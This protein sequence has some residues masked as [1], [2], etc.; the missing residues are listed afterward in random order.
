M[1]EL[2]DSGKI[3][4]DQIPA[5]RPFEV[6]TVANQTERLAIEGALAG[7]IAIQQDTSTSFILNNDLDSQFLAFD[8]DPTVQ[9]TLGDIFTGSTSGGRIQATEYRTGVVH[10]INITD[11]GS[12]YTSP[13]AVTFAGGNPGLG[14]ISCAATTTIANGEVV[15][16]TIVEFNG[17]KGG[18]GYTSAPTVNIA[19]PSGAGTGATATAFIESR[20]YGDVVNRILIADTDTFDSSDIPPVTIDITRVVNTSSNNNNNW[21]SLSSNQIAATDITSGVIETDRLASGGAA[22]SFTF[23]RGDQNFA[24]AVQSIKGSETRYFA[25]LLSQANSGSSQLEF[26]TNSDV[27]VGH[28]VKNTVVGIQA[29]TNITGVITDAQLGGTTISLN[30]PITQNIAAGTIIEFERGGSP[31]VFESSYTKVILLIALLSYL[32]VMDLP[33]VNTSMLISILLQV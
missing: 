13:P 30:N 12:G 4:I 26:A 15:T 10:R 1:V 16:I 22:N 5:L 8:V 14:A 29:N 20:L 23:L 24:L 21:V 18:K 3:S 17:L 31:M 33:I 2:T 19:G 7:D 9:F 27:L 11:G 28:E 6:Y 32:V 25:K